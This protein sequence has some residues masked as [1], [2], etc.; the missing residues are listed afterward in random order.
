M[1]GRPRSFDTDEALSLA[2]EAFWRDGYRD[3]SV[4][5]LTEAIGINPPSLYAAFGDKQQ[6]FSRAADLYIERFRAGL[7]DSLEQP[8]AREGIAELLCITAFHHTEPGKPPG[9]LVLSEPRLLDERNRMRETIASR[10][11]RGR[12]AGDVP[13]DADPGRLAEFIDVVLVGMSA[14][15][16]DGAG[17]DE[18]SATAELALAAFPAPPPPSSQKRSGGGDLS[19]A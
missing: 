16:R 19:P 12:A 18:L 7:T 9:C 2:L 3:T 8:T 5:A 10:I 1:S 14:R 11:E 15:A 6:L 4:A 13:A 17:H